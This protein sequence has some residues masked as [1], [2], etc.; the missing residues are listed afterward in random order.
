MS[1]WSTSYCYR[2]VRALLALTA[3]LFTLTSAPAFAITVT[4][5][6]SQNHSY[7]GGNGFNVTTQTVILP[8]DFTNA[9]IN[10]T[11]VYAND[12][13]VL[14]VNGTNIVGWG[15]FGPGNGGFAFSE[16]G[17]FAPFT[18]ALGHGF[19]L[20]TVN[21]SYSAPFVVGSNII[22]VF[23]NDNGA[24]I[25]GSSFSVANGELQFNANLTYSTSAAAVPE[26]STSALLLAGCFLV[27]ATA[28]RRTSS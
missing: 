8:S 21:Q 1:N 20:A 23:H 10:I 24:G 11:S 13:A 15:I 22:K 4:E 9:L 26:P 27:G 2:P 18:Y 6:I 5:D 7:P 19:S 3:A 25:N 14:Q 28:Y 16:S 12:A 17:P